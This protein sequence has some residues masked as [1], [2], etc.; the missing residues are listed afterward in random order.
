MR[1]RRRQGAR[2]PSTHPHEGAPPCPAPT[3]LPQ[4]YCVLV[5][6]GFVIFFR[7]LALLALNKLNFQSR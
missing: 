6:C 4:G 5:L 2:L 1:Q 3:P 7:L